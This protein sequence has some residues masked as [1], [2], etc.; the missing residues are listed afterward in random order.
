[1]SNTNTKDIFERNIRQDED[2]LFREWASKRHPF[3]TDGCANPTSFLQSRQRIV[4]ALKERNWGHTISDQ[5][6]LQIGAREEIVEERDIFSDWWTLMAQ[7]ADVLL[8]DKDANES[9]QQIQSRHIPSEKMTTEERARWINEKNKRSLGKCACIQLKKSPGGGE[10]NKEDFLTIVREDG[11]LILRQLSIY[12]PHFVV[13]CGSNDSWIAFKEHIFKD[14]KVNQ[15]TNGIH[16]F[17]VQMNNCNHKTAIVNF[18]H[19][20]MRIN[21]T[22]WGVLA[23]GLRETLEEIFCKLNKD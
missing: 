7:W 18:G 8:P 13:S 5:R 15:S 10:L 6:E 14:Q 4:F 19:P 11:D 12:S 17:I 3:A 16:Y 9:W 20:S 2:S 22:L 23:F 1:M 21:S